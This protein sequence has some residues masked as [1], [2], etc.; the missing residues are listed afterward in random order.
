MRVK[1]DLFDIRRRID[2]DVKLRGILRP[3]FPDLE[4]KGDFLAAIAALRAGG[5]DELAFYNYGHLRRPNLQWIGDALR[6]S[7]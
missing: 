3:S 2:K 1:A 6:G 5:V 7:A 4:S